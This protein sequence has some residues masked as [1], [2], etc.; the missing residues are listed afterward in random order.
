M[1]FDLLGHLLFRRGP[2]GRDGDP[3]LAHAIKELVR[4]R[5]PISLRWDRLDDKF[6][7]V[8]RQSRHF[9]EDRDVIGCAALW[10]DIGSYDLRPP[11]K[12]GILEGVNPLVAE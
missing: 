8:D 10:Q 2:G 9:V 6:D 12:S 1:R 7:P 4:E 3:F 5:C 11:E